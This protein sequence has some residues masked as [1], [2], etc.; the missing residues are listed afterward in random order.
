LKKA[1]RP[2]FWGEPDKYFPTGVLK[3]KGFHRGV[4]KKCDM[5]F[6]NMD[7]SREICGDPNCVP[8]ESFAFIGKTPAKN[9]LTYVEVWQKFS[10]MFEGFGYT[11]VKRYPVV[12][13]WNPTMEYTNASIA[14]FQPFVIS[15]EVSPPANPLTIPQVSLRF[16]D[17]DNVGIT[18]S[19]MTGFVMIGRTCLCPQTN[20]IR[21]KRLSAC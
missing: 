21:T 8:G 1:Y 16:V 19:H 5:P 6:W 13:R 3:S 18:Q 9:R 2:V 14:A 11:P 12:A 15:G 4:C 10:E 17:I 7:A 20:G